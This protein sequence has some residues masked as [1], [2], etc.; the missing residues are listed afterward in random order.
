MGFGIGVD[1]QRSRYEG[2]GN[3]KTRGGERVVSRTGA[4]VGVKLKLGSAVGIGRAFRAREVSGKV[5][6]EGRGMGGWK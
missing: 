2:I 1:D 3:G 4:E 5:A 6:E